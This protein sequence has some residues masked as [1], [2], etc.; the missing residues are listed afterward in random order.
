MVQ[1]AV[2]E[3]NFQLYFLYSVLSGTIVSHKPLNCFLS[4][5]QAQ[6]WLIQEKNLSS[7]FLFFLFEW[8]S[9]LFNLAGYL[10]Y[11]G[12]GCYSSTGVSL[13]WS[14]LLLLGLSNPSGILFCFNVIWNRLQYWK[15]TSNCIFCIQCYLEQLYLTNLWTVFWV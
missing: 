14:S 2:L 6:N 12:G 8:E 10:G 7:F 5:S 13:C 3:G 1:P 9:F 11:I 4:L 15:A